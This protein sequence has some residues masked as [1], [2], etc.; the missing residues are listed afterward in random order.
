MDLKVVTRALELTDHGLGMFF[1]LGLFAS[2]IL[3][4]ARQL[5]RRGGY[6]TSHLSRGLA[7]STLSALF[8][9]LGLAGATAQTPKDPALTCDPGD[10]GIWAPLSSSNHDNLIQLPDRSRVVPG[11]VVVLNLRWE[12]RDWKPGT[13]LHIRACTDIEGQKEVD[14]KATPPHEGPQFDFDAIHPKEPPESRAGEKD[15][16]V[17]S[18]AITL[19]VPKDAAPGE[20]CTRVA[21]TGDSESH[22]GSSPTFDIAETACL[23]IIAPPPASPPAPRAA[24]PPPRAAPPPPPAYLSKQLPVTGGIDARLIALALGL[25]GVGIAL[26][27]K[28]NRARKA[29]SHPPRT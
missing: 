4:L 1:P 20:L 17:V 24:P 16:R 6:K 22:A 29:V 19:R 27:L 3:L 8:F 23:A 28:A 26:E 7:L 18:H 21:M 2:S 5:L 9:S 13:A 12:W 25:L 14:G 15:R 10:T 11:E